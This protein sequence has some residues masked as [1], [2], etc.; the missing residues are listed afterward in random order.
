MTDRCRPGPGWRKLSGGV[1]ERDNLRV[2]MLGVCRLP[3]GKII[4]GMA[5][6]EYY[7]L[8]HMVRIN[9][10]NR[11]RGLMAWAARLDVQ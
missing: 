1:Y 10:D 5:V 4:S 11:K 9:G 8:S 6:P 7:T 2:H 3:G